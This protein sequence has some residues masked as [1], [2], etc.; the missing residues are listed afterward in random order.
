MT[1]DHLHQ[2]DLG[3]TLF[4]AFTREAGVGL[5]DINWALR[6]AA[7]HEEGASRR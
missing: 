3:T 7:I 1:L 6:Y 2:L 5:G 4:P